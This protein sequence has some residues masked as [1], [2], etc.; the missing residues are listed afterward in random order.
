ML[1]LAAHGIDQTVS[2]SQRKFVEN[3]HKSPKIVGTAILRRASGDEHNE[4]AC[5]TLL[6]YLGEY[7]LTSKVTPPVLVPKGQQTPRV[8]TILCEGFDETERQILLETLGEM[9]VQAHVCPAKARPVNDEGNEPT[10]AVVVS[11]A[12]AA[13]HSAKIISRCLDFVNSLPP[14]GP[15]EAWCDF[16]HIRDKWGISIVVPLFFPTGAVTTFIPFNY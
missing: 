10:Q 13:S 4:A 15:T 9:A 7:S 3:F 8:A 2:E 16:C 5:K 1:S 12:V 11:K 6:R 14:L